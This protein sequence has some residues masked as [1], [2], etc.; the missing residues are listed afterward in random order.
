MKSSVFS[1]LPPHILMR[2]SHTSSS[3]YLPTPIQKGLRRVRL[4]NLCFQEIS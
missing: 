2:K 1:A 4:S 3:S